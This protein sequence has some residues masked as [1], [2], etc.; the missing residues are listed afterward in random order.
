MKTAKLGAIFLVSVMAL[1]GTGAA[2][3][4]WFDYL[5]I[6]GWVETGEIGAEII[7]GLCWDTEPPE[8]DFSYIECWTVDDITLVVHVFNAYPCIWYYQEF[9]IHNSG[10]IPIHIGEIYWYS[11]DIVDMG[12][13]TVTFTGI[14]P[15]TQ[16]HP[17]ETVTGTI[18][19]H[20]NNFAIQ[21]YDYYF[22]L[23]I[24]YHQWNE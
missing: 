1:A 21:D 17:C 19:V 11:N 8:K 5:Y 13:G 24:E 7:P 6:D 20:L 18:E 16:I 4:L 14:N 3:A 10:T 23:D 2:Y 15:G 9:D 12:H 22:Y